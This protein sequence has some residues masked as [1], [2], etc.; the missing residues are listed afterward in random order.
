MCGKICIK[1]R[2]GGYLD[3][4]EYENTAS[5]KESMLVSSCL[6]SVKDRTEDFD[7]WLT[8]ELPWENGL[9]SHSLWCSSAAWLANWQK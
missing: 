1:F 6:F 2:G 3:R 5:N 4:K 8:V 7:G 9:K